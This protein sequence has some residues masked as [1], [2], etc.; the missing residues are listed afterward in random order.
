MPHNRLLVKEE[1]ATYAETL[2]SAASAASAEGQER[3]LTVRDQLEQVVFLYRGNADLRDAFDEIAYTA[4]QRRT[5]A[6][7]VFEGF[8]PLLAS[9]LSVMAERQ[10]F[11]ELSQINNAFAALIDER[12]GLAVVDVTTV[13]ELDDELRTLISEK[14]AADLGK[15]VVLREHVDPSILGGIIMSTQG[16]RIDA[17]IVSKL[18]QARTVLS[19]SNDGGEC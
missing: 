16:K 7:G 12:L 4:E 18:E 1:I 5:I 6:Q 11:S 17:S 8:D 15:S 13:V 10:D 19:E 9:V 2:F 14:V 3:V